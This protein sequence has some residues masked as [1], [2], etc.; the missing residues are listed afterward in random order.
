MARGGGVLKPV[1][2]SNSV[3][4]VNNLFVSGNI[5][6]TGGASTISCNNLN[7]TGSI[8]IG[9]NTPNTALDLQGNF[10]LRNRYTVQRTIQSNNNQRITIPITK[11]IRYITCF[12]N[13][14]LTGIG[15]NSS[16][17]TISK[18]NGVFD[19]IYETNVICKVLETNGNSIYVQYNA[20]SNSAGSFLIDIKPE[21]AFLDTTLFNVNIEI[22]ASD[23]IT[24]GLETITDLGSNTSLPALTLANTPNT[25]IGGGNVGIGTENPLSKLDVFGNI[26][27]GS[28]GVKTNIMQGFGNTPI[29]IDTGLS[30]Y[31][32]SGG[33][34]ILI[35]FSF[36]TSGGDNTSTGLYCIRKYYDTSNI[37]S[38]MSSTRTTLADM[39]GNSFYVTSF[40]HSGNGTLVA[41]ISAAGGSYKWYAITM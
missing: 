20:T 17:Y 27:F 25:V 40:S 37:W 34:T 6:A 3:Q 39:R 18:Y 16:A 8:G 2:N 22:Q 41:N 15:P 23:I 5:G 10:K 13:V 35:A 4:S 9:I 24:Y 30:L 19:G 21:I 28:S 31:G 32:G 7:A 33:G 36:H 14:Y 11:L 29:S 26:F 1:N 38:D 12:V